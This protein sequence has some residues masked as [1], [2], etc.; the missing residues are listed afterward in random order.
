[1][2][3]S[4]LI[5]DSRDPI[6][7][8]VLDI[9]S[10]WYA[11]GWLSHF[12]SISTSEIESKGPNVASALV[13]EAASRTRPPN[14]KRVLDIRD[15]DEIRLIVLDVMGE[16]PDW[17][18]RREELHSAAQ[19]LNQALPHRTAAV[20]VLVPYF[21]ARWEDIPSWPSWDTVICAPEQSNSLEQ[22]G[23]PLFASRSNE[24]ELDELAAHAGAFVASA[25]GLW[26]GMGQGYFDETDHIDD[27]R[28]GRSVHRRVDASAMADQLR[29]L[30]F[31]SEMIRSAEASSALS[32]AVLSERA[33]ALRPLINTVSSPE[34]KPGPTVQKIGVWAAI[35]MFVSFMFSALVRAPVDVARSMTYR[36]KAGAATTLQNVI[37]GTESNKVIL[38]GGVA[39]S[40]PG[41][42][43][44][45]TEEKLADLD[46]KLRSVPGLVIPETAIGAS[47]RSFWQACFDNAFA[48]VSGT[49]QGRGEVCIQE[50]LPRYFPVDQVAPVVGNW[51][52]EGELVSGIPVAGIE[53]SDVRAVRSAR[54]VLEASQQAEY[55]WQGRAD[56]HL[57]TLRDA[58]S[59]WLSSFMG[60]VGL[61]ISSGLGSYEQRVADLLAALQAV[62]QVDTD[63]AED[64][65]KGLRR[66][67][68]IAAAG[69]AGVVAVAWLLH[70]V[71]VPGVP[72]L[73]IT[74]VASIGLV[75]AV[76]VK[77][78]T[79]KQKLFQLQHR[80]Q[81]E[82]EYR[83]NQ[84]VVELPVAVEN[85]R[86]LARLYAQYRVWGPV[87]SAFLS[88]PFGVAQGRAAQF[89]GMTG[90]VPKSVSCGVYADAAIDDSARVAAGI[91]EGMRLPVAQLWAEFARLSHEV[92]VSVRPQ[93][94]RVPADDLFGQ[95]DTQP[96]A[97]L[98]QWA[99]AT[100]DP[101]SEEPKLSGVVSA[102]MDR[103]QMQR[104][105]DTVPEDALADLR[106][107]YRIG[108]VGAGGQ[109]PADRFSSVRPARFD[110][111]FLSLEGIKEEVGEVAVFE[112]FPSASSRH[113]LPTRNWLDEVDTA[114]ILTKRTKISAFTLRNDVDE[115]GS[116]GAPEPVLREM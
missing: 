21:G 96:D 14:T 35:K 112:V 41:E 38:V 86:R 3:E 11:S 51:R 104:L 67:T 100:L 72:A 19:L 110:T 52:P 17:L 93:F 26:T 43:I 103:C 4:L 83:L 77:S 12:S 48:L 16:S 10:D 74:G 33:E 88:A 65:I 32:M 108:Q 39:A 81:Q 9:L 70:L 90:A 25:T 82:H 42:D 116:D 6:S 46:A 80:R 13:R 24:Q 54:A 63:E 15:S 20:D 34:P 5:L 75:V 105:L 102:D 87:L 49:R 44:R 28:A 61:M 55:G 60:Q 18:Q 23:L 40:T 36:V 27:I 97:F 79:T 50:G 29:D 92:F 59:P 109:P 101:A 58:A 94:Q 84:V 1:M 7:V 68:G 76:L 57:V 106:R 47:Q 89:P 37:F 53:L 111:S 85:A 107:T 66:F 115:V 78:A 62:S 114:L 113:D 95:S 56:D 73:L 8:R 2:P 69:V 71:L 30:S 64:L 22:P 91:A 98:L 45:A 31:R 99:G